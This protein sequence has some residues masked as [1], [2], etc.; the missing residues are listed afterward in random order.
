MFG[1]DPIDDLDVMFPSPSRK[2]ELLTNSEFARSLAERIEQAHHWAR[3][4]MG[5]AAT[6]Q[7]RNYQRRPKSFQVQDLVWLFTPTLGAR[8]STKMTS[9]WSGPWEV[10]EKVNDLVYKIEASPESNYEGVAT[11]SIDRMRL[12]VKD[13]D[14]PSPK[15]EDPEEVEMPGNEFATSIPGRNDAHPPSYRGPDLGSDPNLHEP[16]GEITT[17]STGPVAPAPFDLLGASGFSPPP[18][19]PGPIQPGSHSAQPVKPFSYDPPTSTVLK[20][21]QEPEVADWP[22]GL[23]EGQE[24]PAEEKGEETLFVPQQKPV[25]EIEHRP[26][27]SKQFS[28]SESE[29][30]VGLSSQTGQ[31]IST[32]TRTPERKVFD[33]PCQA[34]RRKNYVARYGHPRCKSPNLMKASRP[35]SELRVVEDPVSPIIQ[36]EPVTQI[37][38]SMEVKTDTVKASKIPKPVKPPVVDLP[39]G[40][41]RAY[42]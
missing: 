16:E 2:R 11:V 34:R 6:R 9:N 32:P 35:M 20:W 14:H 26:P 5:L 27:I 21:D 36:P 13:V 37:E 10:K 40:F 7:R 1:R 30:D 24:S 18:N 33:D 23:E 29:E 31:K 41:R 15:L 22:T 42:D 28:T 19:L 25:L 12:Y 8:G 17:F 38:A 3:V 4:N 39:S